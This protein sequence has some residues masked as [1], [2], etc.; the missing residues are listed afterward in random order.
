MMVH[1]YQWFV[2]DRADRIPGL[3]EKRPR[4]GNVGR[5]WR[6]A[7]RWRAPDLPLN[8]GAVVVTT[9]AA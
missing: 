1:R 7:G 5:S 8:P 4:F 9:K 3:D 2:L 6:G